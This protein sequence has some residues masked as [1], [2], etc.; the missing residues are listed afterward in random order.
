MLIL[1]VFL[2]ECVCFLAIIAEVA[3]LFAIILFQQIEFPE[4]HEP[5]GEFCLT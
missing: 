4:G 3:P 2:A 1:H 5:F